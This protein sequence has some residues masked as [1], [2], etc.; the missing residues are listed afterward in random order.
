METKHIHFSFINKLKR[1]MLSLQILF[2]LTRNAEFALI[3][4]QLWLLIVF[5]RDLWTRAM[6]LLSASTFTLAVRRSI[7]SS[8]LLSGIVSRLVGVIG[9]KDDDVRVVDS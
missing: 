1:E 8:L 4:V 3:K 9:R 7:G 5:N 2:P 6:F